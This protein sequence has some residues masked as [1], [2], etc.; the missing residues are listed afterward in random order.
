MAAAESFEAVEP[1]RASID[2][3]T[4]PLV[5]EFGAP[6]CGWCRAA[7]PLVREALAHHPDVRHMK[8]EDGSGRPLGRSFR[9]KLWP[10]LIFLRDGVEVGRVTRPADAGE[11][12]RNVRRIAAGQ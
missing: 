5:L 7:I 9:I 10:T 12:E 1:A 11:I 3:S 8:V 4:G 2:A 6:W